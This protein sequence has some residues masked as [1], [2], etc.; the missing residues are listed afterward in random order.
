MTIEEKLKIANA[1]G[2]FKESGHGSWMGTLIRRGERYGQVTSDSNGR[3]RVLEVTF[4]DGTKEEIRLNNVGPDEKEVHEYEWY[5][6]SA[7]KGTWGRFY[8]G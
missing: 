2:S 8:R 6:E 7:G 1:G 5:M 3:Y 4:Q